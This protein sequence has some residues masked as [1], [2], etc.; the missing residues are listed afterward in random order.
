MVARRTLLTAAASALVLPRSL[1]AAEPVRVGDVNSYTRMAAFTEPYRKGMRLA[2]EQANA[3]GGAGGRQVELI[4]RDDAGEPGEAV[5]VAEEMLARDRV[6]LLSGGF[7]SN[8]GLAL[9]S[10]AKQRKQLYLAGEPLADALVWQ[11]GNR[12]TFRLR[13]ST[14]MQSNMLA[15]VAAKKPAKRWA[16]IAPNYAYGKEAVDAFK[17]IMG[18]LRPDVTWVAEQWPPLF[19]MTPGPRFRPSPRPSL[20]PCTTSPSAPT[21][22]SWC[23]RGPTAASSTANASSSAC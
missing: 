15:Q 13:P 2:V 1:C 18:R 11:D 21:S 9:A 4:S 23:S 3:K 8:V 6:A 12:Y 10:L 19:K 7:F 5:R 20:R 14:Y 17:R 22:P 16:T